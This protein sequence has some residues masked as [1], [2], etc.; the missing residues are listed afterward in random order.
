MPPIRTDKSRSGD[1]D[2]ELPSLRNMYISVSRTKPYV[3]NK[4]NCQ[5]NIVDDCFGLEKRVR[6]SSID[7]EQVKFA[8]EDLL[9]VNIEMRYENDDEDGEDWCLVWP[10]SESGKLGR[11]SDDVSLQAAVQDYRRAGKSIVELSVIK[12]KGNHAFNKLEL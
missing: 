12:N 1:Y 8:I 7:F 6:L 11:I 10:M 3:G 5:L 2:K 4:W 9:D